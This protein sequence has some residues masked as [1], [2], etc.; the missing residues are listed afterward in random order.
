[1]NRREMLTAATSVIGVGIVGATTE[2]NVTFK[3]INQRL[4]NSQMHDLEN[5]ECGWITGGSVFMSKI[6]KIPYF[7]I[8]ELKQVL[9]Y[10]PNWD[11]YA[12]WIGK[13]NNNFY[14]SP[15]KKILED[16]NTWLEDPEK[17]CWAYRPAQLAYKK[18]YPL[19]NSLDPLQFLHKS[20]DCWMS[21]D[22]ETAVFV[23]PSDWN[24]CRKHPL[25]ERNLLLLKDAITMMDQLRH[26]HGFHCSPNEGHGDTEKYLK[27]VFGE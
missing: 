1:M 6:D 10:K 23:I 7:S 16:L 17:D 4:C 12:T 5:G 8:G 21:M 18:A 14:I 26:Q 13:H 3:T 20:K 2:S 15:S 19:E 9:N 22:T 25:V 11:T 27:E 24:L